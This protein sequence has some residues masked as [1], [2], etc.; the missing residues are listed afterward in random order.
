LVD[1]GGNLDVLVSAK[2]PAGTTIDWRM[3]DP[4]DS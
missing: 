1:V 4:S 2:G 3:I